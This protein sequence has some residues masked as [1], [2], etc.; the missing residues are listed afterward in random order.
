MRAKFRTLAFAICAM[1]ATGLFAGQYI[2]QASDHDD[3]EVDLK[4][5]SLNL[6][7]LYVFREDNQTGNAND[8]GNLILIMNSNPRSLPGQQYFFSTTAQYDFHL[9]QV[10]TA[11]K[12]KRPTGSDD[13]VLRFQF[14]TPTADG[15][16]QINFTLIKKGQSVLVDKTSSGSALLTTPLAASQNNSPT[17]NVVNVNEAPVTIFAGLREDPFFFDVEQ[18]FKVREAALKTGKFIGFLPTNQ[19]KDFT[20][21]YNINTIVVRVPIAALQSSATDTVFDAWTT[22]SVPKGVVR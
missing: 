22:I 2:V 18:F 3:G 5:R 14:S 12:A 15:K 13:V 7:D 10:A 6:T 1:V 8:K 19:A 11:N 21:N 4:G 20:H 16:Q 9:S 17:L